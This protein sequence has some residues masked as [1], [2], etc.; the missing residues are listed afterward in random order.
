MPVSIPLK[1]LSPQTI[2][3]TKP[4]YVVTSLPAPPGETVGPTEEEQSLSSSSSSDITPEDLQL[5]ED[6]KDHEGEEHIPQGDGHQSAPGE[7]DYSSSSD[8]S[9]SSSSSSSSS[10]TDPLAFAH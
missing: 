5:L 8:E 1:Q 7:A 2:Q 10:S 9:D 3:S 4:G 6:P